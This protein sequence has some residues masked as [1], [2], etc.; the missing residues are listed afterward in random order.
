MSGLNARQVMF[1]Q[2][3]AF[4]SGGNLKFPTEGR[5]ALHESSQATTRGRTAPGESEHEDHTLVELHFAYGDGSHTTPN[6]WWAA[7]GGYCVWRPK[8]PGQETYDAM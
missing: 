7:L 1:R 4:G 5:I 6:K 3:Q 8:W 2:K